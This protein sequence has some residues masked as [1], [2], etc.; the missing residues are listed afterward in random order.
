[1]TK[2]WI[3]ILSLCF[4]F[5]IFGCEDKKSEDTKLDFIASFPLKIVEPSGLTYDGTNLWTVSDEEGM[6]YKIDTEGVI[7]DSI[8]TEFEDLEGIAWDSENNLLWVAD[9]LDS[10]IYVLDTAGTVR[11]TINPSFTGSYLSLEGLCYRDSS[12]CAAVYYAVQEAEAD[13]GGGASYPLDFKPSGLD[14]AEDRS[15]TLYIVSDETDCL[16]KWKSGIHPEILE[17]WEL[18]S[19]DPEGVAVVGNRVYVVDDSE[20]RLDIYI[21]N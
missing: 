13:M 4:L 21:L 17:Q 8:D 18:R 9:E 6:I 5:V 16:Y 3:A 10:R 20:N 7:L 11:D 19:D 2:I 1:M 15:F 14:Y 12:F